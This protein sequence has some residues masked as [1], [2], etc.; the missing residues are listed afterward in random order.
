MNVTIILHRGS[1]SPLLNAVEASGKTYPFL[2]TAIEPDTRR[3]PYRLIP[4]TNPE[5]LTEAQLAELFQRREVLRADWEE[6][7][8]HP[9]GL[10]TIYLP[11]EDGA[12]G[13]RQARFDLGPELTLELRPLRKLPEP[14]VAP[15]APKPKIEPKNPDFG[16]LS[17]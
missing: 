9:L 4:S 2:F 1:T 5:H 10:I 16:G 12:S 15:R 17:F 11:P 14:D 8:G 6:Q 3:W 7:E 13:A